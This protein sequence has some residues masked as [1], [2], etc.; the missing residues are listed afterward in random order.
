MGVITS[1]PDTIKLN[2]NEM[3]KGKGDTF[4][5]DS[6]NYENSYRWTGKACL[7]LLG[8]KG[9]KKILF[10]LN[11]A[12]DKVGKFNDCLAKVLFHVDSVCIYGTGMV[13]FEDKIW[14]NHWKLCTIEVCRI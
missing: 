9:Y 12:G 1:V 2:L 5:I 13:F 4:V 8:N 7:A 10:K 11:L 14:I 3:M 6:Q